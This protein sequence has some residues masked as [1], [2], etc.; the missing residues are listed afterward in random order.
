MKLMKYQYGQGLS[1]KMAGNLWSPPI[2]S[3]SGG[4]NGGGGGGVNGKKRKC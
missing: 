3:V 1:A 4:V 2:F